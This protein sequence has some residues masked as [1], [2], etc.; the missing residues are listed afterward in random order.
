VPLLSHLTS[1][2]PTKSKLFRANNF[3]AAAVSERAL[4]RLLTF[5]VPNLMS[6]FH[7]LGRTEVLFQ[8]RGFPYK[9]FV[10]RYGEELLAPRPTPKPEGHLLSAARDCLFNIIAS[11]LHTGSRSSFRNLGTRHAVVTGTHLSRLV[12]RYLEI[13]MLRFCTAPHRPIL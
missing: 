5:Q 8:V 1:C 11:T 2:T 9:C 13:F 3:L 12:T 4:Y 6:P 10:T 7:C